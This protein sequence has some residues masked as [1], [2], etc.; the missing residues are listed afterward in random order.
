MAQGGRCFQRVAV[1]NHPLAAAI[2]LE[3]LAP[4]ARTIVELA[5]LKGLPLRR[6]SARLGL[7]KSTAWDRLAAAM[8]ALKRSSGMDS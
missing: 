7:S 3:K 4:E 6:V 1:P 5:Y 8:L 2:A